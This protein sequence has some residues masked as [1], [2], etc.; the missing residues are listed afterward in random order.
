MPDGRFLQVVIKNNVSYIFVCMLQKA[1]REK[2][3]NYSVKY[4]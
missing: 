4:V 2:L 1:K 3:I